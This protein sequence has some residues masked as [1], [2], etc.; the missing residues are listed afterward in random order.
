MRLSIVMTYYNRVQQ[1]A[2]TLRSIRLQLQE[3]PAPPS[4]EIIIVDDASTLGQEARTVISKFPDLNIKLLEFTAKEKWWINPC[5]PYNRGFK[6]ATGDIVIIQNP[7]CVHLGNI[8]SHTLDNVTDKNYL[9]WSCLSTFPQDHARFEPLLSCPD[10]DFRH[11]LL[12]L[13]SPIGTRPWYTHRHIY[14]VNYHFCTALTRKNLNQI[15]GFNEEFA[16][17]YCFDD[18]EFLLRIQRQE[19][20]IQPMST[21]IGHV[22]HQYHPKSATITS[23]GP[24]WDRNKYRYCIELDRFFAELT[25]KN[26]LAREQHER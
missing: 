2:V 12:E 20:Q 7:E 9:V 10:K 16:D 18:N 22:I 21:T 14:P 1:L 8:L 24:E 5:I 11:K 26:E 25:K 6:L 13:I 4:P 15:G 23:V 17:G 19:L 3:C